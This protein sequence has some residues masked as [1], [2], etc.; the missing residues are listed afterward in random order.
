MTVQ[1]HIGDALN[2]LAFLGTETVDCVV[3]S[4]PYYCQRDYGV[5]GQLG[6]ES[7]PDEYVA[8]LAKVFSEIFRVLKPRGVVWLNIGDSY[9]SG[10]GQPK[11]RDPRS[12]NRNWMRKKKRPLDLPGMGV[13]KKSL[14]GIPWRVVL[15]LQAQGWTVRSDIIWCRE[16]A[17]A[18]PSVKDRPHQQHEH[19]FLLSKARWYDFDR[20]ALKEQSVWHFPHQR[21]RRGHP[22]VFP[23]ELVE[24]CILAGCP[25]NGVVLDPFAGSGTTGAVA[26]RLGRDAIL[27][28]LSEEYAGLAQRRIQGGA[29]LF[30]AADQ[31]SVE[32]DT[33]K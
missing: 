16:T 10:N 28:E 20:S 15:A 3:T 9:Y 11:G 18:E 2:Q 17:L 19:I 26:E 5:A 12:P 23:E 24:R 33:D 22:A 14:L 31:I 32:R 21:G 13:P 30:S 27:I 25:N 8:A 29:S 1:I 7:H 4:P 6:H